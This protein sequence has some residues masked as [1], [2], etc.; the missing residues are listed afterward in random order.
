MPTETVYGLAASA[1]DPAAIKKIFQAKGRPQD[2]PLIVHISNLKMLQPLVTAV[3]EPAKKL[4]E[5]FWPGPLTMIFPK[6]EKV[7]M[8]VTAGMETVA[9]RF[10]SHP[11][12]QA[13]IRESSLP[14]AAPSANL[15][16][17][18]SPTTAQHVWEDMDG[19]IPLIVDGGECQ[20]GVESTVVLVKEDCLHLLRPGA[21][22]P[23]MLKTC[24]DQVEIDPAVLHQ[25]KEGAQA[26]SPGMKYKHYSPKADVTIL[27]G[28][29]A[30]FKEYVNSHWDSATYALV[31]DGEQQGIACPCLT[32]GADAAEQAKELFAVL[33]R[34]DELGVKKV[35]A[36]CPEKQGMGLAVYNRLIRAAGFQVI[37]LEDARM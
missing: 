13:I 17:K 28:N 21:V 18:P 2:N 34:L 16:G 24:C 8:E 36:R 35:Y 29:L 32:Y 27:S 6:S 23:E 25:L 30:Q 14:L 4:A 3:P 12:A 22:T 37:P 15:S 19:K 10:P 20:V 9:I 31:F 26:A 33:R 1:Y 11:V 5:Q 7:P